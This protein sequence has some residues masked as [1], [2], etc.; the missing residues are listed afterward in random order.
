VNG[1]ALSRLADDPRAVTLAVVATIVAALW[2]ALW[3]AMA[4]MPMEA[5]PGAAMPAMA[6]MGMGAAPSDWS[7]VA[8][9]STIAMWLLMMAAMM[10]PSMAPMLSVYAGLA[11]KEDRGALLALRIALFALGY[12][13]LW[14]AFSV[15]AAMG[16]L[17]L[18]E[19]AWFTMGGTL[20]TPVATGV[21][22]LV[23]GAHQFTSVKDLC[24]KHCRHPLAFLM[25]HWREGLAGAFPIGAR[26][27]VYCFGCCVAFMGLMF[28]F[29][30]M[31]VLWMALIALYFLAEKIL[32]HE[33]V[34][35][36]AV[37]VALLAA[38][39]AMLAQGVI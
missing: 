39:A 25:V 2:I 24:L 18:R 15:I 31:N 12:F 32:P 33:R 5:T 10:L 6:G 13:L 8:V 3:Q 11:A 20:A 28:V 21:L 23:A 36:R 1:R 35:G 14:A 27:G 4:G 37:G 19:S 22:L 7:V 30:A 16:Q 29:G 34:W 9:L 26:H 38:G 17:G